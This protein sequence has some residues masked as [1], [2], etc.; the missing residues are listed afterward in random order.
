MRSLKT[1][2]SDN[3]GFL[4]L[5]IPAA[6]TIIGSMVAAKSAKDI[7]KKQIEQSD[8]L[9][10]KQ[11]AETD[12][13]HQREIADLKAAGLNPILSAKYGGS[14]SAQ[15]AM[16]NLKT[17][18][19][20]AGRDF[21]SAAQI[22][23]NTKKTAADINNTKAQ[24]LLNSAEALK[25]R[26]GAIQAMMRTEQMKKAQPYKKSWWKQ[27]GHRAIKDVIDLIPIRPS[28]GAMKLIK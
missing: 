9:F 24:T 21:A 14:A 28:I 25:S 12:T 20:N 15:G 18:F 2:L 13:A 11:K 26:E 3:R 5:L 23:L 19:E 27:R 10:S 6:A 1:V 22:S 4:N 7:N 17:P 16:P 8:K